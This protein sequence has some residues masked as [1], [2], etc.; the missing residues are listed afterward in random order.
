MEIHIYDE[1]PSGTRGKPGV[2]ANR[3]RPDVAAAFPG[4]DANHGYVATVPAEPGRH[5]VCTYAITTGG[6]AGNPQL[7]CR[8]VTV[9]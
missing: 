1:G 4:Y 9:A 6:G 8:D 7:G 3:S 2:I 5:R